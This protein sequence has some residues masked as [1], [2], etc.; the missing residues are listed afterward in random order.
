MTN[1]RR[2]FPV[3]ALLFLCA[4]VSFAQDPKD[5]EFHVVSES[6]QDVVKAALWGPS[7]ESVKPFIHS[8]A[9]VFYGAK[10]EDLYEFFFGEGKA[11]DFSLE[12]HRTMWSSYLMANSGRDAAVMSFRTASADQKDT[13]YHSVFFFKLDSGEWRI[14]HWHISN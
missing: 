3:F 12:Y 1:L 11:N 6:L 5:E 4:S 14:M 7:R 2:A 10:E 13:R 9:S 8:R